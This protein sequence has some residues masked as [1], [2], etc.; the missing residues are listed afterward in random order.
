MVARGRQ[1]DRLGRQAGKERGRETRGQGGCLATTLHFA[2]YLT[3]SYLQ[4]M[5][6]ANSLE[7]AQRFS[8]EGEEGGKGIGRRVLPLSEI[9]SSCCCCWWRWWWT[10][11]EFA[12]AEVSLHLLHLFIFAF[13]NKQ[14]ERVVVVINIA[15][16]HTERER[17]SKTDRQAEAQETARLRKRGD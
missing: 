9:S 16:T 2:R 14:H 4:V 1:T 13:I 15:H 3:C 8:G 6:A 10:A 5:L 17:D 12:A 7:C 11:R